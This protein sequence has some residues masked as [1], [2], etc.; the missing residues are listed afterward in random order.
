VRVAHAALSRLDEIAEEDE[1][2]EDLLSRLR[3]IYELR[4]SRLASLHG[5]GQ[6]DEPRELTTR[7]HEI[8]RQ[9]IAAQRQALD[10]LRTERA[11]SSEAIGRIQHDIDLEEA[12]G[13]R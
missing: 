10:E 4:L 1:L 9:L 11:A 8:R 3:G 7:A 12:R 2:P 5:E 13:G 6:P